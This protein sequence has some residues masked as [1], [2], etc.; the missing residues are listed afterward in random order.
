MSISNKTVIKGE[1]QPIKQR[2]SP[3]NKRAQSINLLSD[4]IPDAFSIS[5]SD[6]I[7]A[8]ISE[9][10]EE[11]SEAFPKSNPE[12]IPEAI[13]EAIPESNS[14][15]SHRST[16]LQEDGLRQWLCEAVGEHLSSRCIAQVDLSVS[17]HIC[18]KI[19]LGRNVCNCSSAVAS[20]LDARD[21]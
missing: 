16:L 4:G 3:R 7:S 10:T 18:S 9:R 2:G 21:H 14:D 19:V 13:S 11:I 17:S 8:T 5:N 20:V 15:H 12:P 1:E 6:T